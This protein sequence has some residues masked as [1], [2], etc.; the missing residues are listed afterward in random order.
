MSNGTGN[1]VNLM[2]KAGATHTPRRAHR[3]LPKWHIALG[4]ASRRTNARM[5]KNNCRW[6]DGQRSDKS[7]DADIWEIQNSKIYSDLLNRNDFRS[8]VRR[9]DLC[10]AQQKTE[11]EAARNFRTE[12]RY[13]SF[14]FFSVWFGLFSFFHHRFRISGDAFADGWCGYLSVLRALDAIRPMNI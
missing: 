13:I 2:P 3:T 5:Q 11:G 6:Q 4:G 9:P 10:F 14:Y 12:N 7:D 1:N 8:V